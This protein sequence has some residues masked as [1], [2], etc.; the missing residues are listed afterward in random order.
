MKLTVF[1]SPRELS[2]PGQVLHDRR[3]VGV[4]YK[5]QVI[6]SVC[7]PSVLVAH[8]LVNQKLQRPHISNPKRVGGTSYISIASTT[9]FGGYLQRNYLI[10]SKQVTQHSQIWGQLGLC[11]GVS[12]GCTHMPLRQHSTNGSNTLHTS[13]VDI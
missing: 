1:W 4:P 6:S 9:L 2:P 13:N 11:N 10:F 5:L 12:T 7:E 8:N 3:L